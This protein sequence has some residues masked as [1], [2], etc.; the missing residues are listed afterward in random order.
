[1][2]PVTKSHRLAV[3]RAWEGKNGPIEELQRWADAGNVGYVV[4]LFERLAQLVADAEGAWVPPPPHHQDRERRDGDMS[5]KR[6]VWFVEFQDG[7]CSMYG[8]ETKAR[9]VGSQNEGYVMQYVPAEQ[10]ARYGRRPEPPGAIE[11]D[12]RQYRKALETIRRY[13]P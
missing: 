3:A 5:S 13:G 2:A 7:T 12:E 9:E 1:M 6:E 8:S 4:D 11:I 10:P